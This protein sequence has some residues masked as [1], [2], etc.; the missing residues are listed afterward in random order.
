M[1]KEQAPYVR[2]KDYDHED[3]DTEFRADTWLTITANVLA[4]IGV[5]AALMCAIA[6]TMQIPDSW[7]A[8]LI[9]YIGVI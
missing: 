6:I 3:V 1:L 4:S 7:F 9:N 8:W 5:F 2:M